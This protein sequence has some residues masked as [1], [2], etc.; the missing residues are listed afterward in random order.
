MA[1]WKRET[2]I[3]VHIFTSIMPCILSVIGLAA[4]GVSIVGDKF[5]TGSICLSLAVAAYFSFK[6]MP[7]RSEEG[8]RQLEQVE[9]LAMYIGTA[10]S[11][12]LKILNAPEDSLEIYEKLLPYAVALGCAEAWNKRFASVL[13]DLDYKP[14]WFDGDLL[15][16]NR[17]TGAINRSAYAA[18]RY[19]MNNSLVDFTSSIFSG[20]SG[21]SG[22]SSGG[23]SGGGGGRG[24]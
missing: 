4:L 1:A 7:K 2:N 3:I 20:S 23:G 22:G 24:W 19:S 10:E 6:L 8:V 18:S 12:R 17:T 21:T 13:A 5:L 9:G 11:E 15:S 14:D 16:L